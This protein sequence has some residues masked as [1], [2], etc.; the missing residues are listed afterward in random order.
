MCILSMAVC[1][2]ETL[3]M[4]AAFLVG[5]NCKIE[6]THILVLDFKEEVL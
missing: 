6:E 5:L 4:A 3:K 2:I 1:K